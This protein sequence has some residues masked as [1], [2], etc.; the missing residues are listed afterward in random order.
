MASPSV[1]GAGEEKADKEL[2]KL[3]TRLEEESDR[4]AG[5]IRRFQIVS[6]IA[7]AL[8]CVLLS[9][10]DFRPPKWAHVQE[11]LANWE[12]NNQIQ[13]AVRSIRYS[14]IENY[15]F[16]QSVRKPLT[17]SVVKTGLAAD[18]PAER[19]MQ[20][21]SEFL[22]DKYYGVSFLDLD[23]L[24]KYLSLM[25]EQAGANV[26]KDLSNYGYEGGQRVATGT[27][28]RQAF[29]SDYTLGKHKRLAL[30][31]PYEPEKDIRSYVDAARNLIAE[32]KRKYPEADKAWTGVKTG[33]LRNYAV[34]AWTW[35]A[36]TGLSDNAVAEWNSI[37]VGSVGGIDSETI[38]TISGGQGL[39][40]WGSVI[41]W[42]K[43]Q[44][45]A[46]AEAE[47]ET[48]AKATIWSVRVA[49]PLK[50]MVLLFPLIY[51]AARC[52][53]AELRLYLRS[54]VARAK[55]IDAVIDRGLGVYRPL[56]EGLRASLIEPQVI[57]SGWNTIRLFPLFF[58]EFAYEMGAFL[59]AAYVLYRGI[60]LAYYH[61]AT[62]INPI[63]YSLM[64]T[65]ALLLGLSFLRTSRSAI[66]KLSE[67][68]TVTTQ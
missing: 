10:Q 12:A 41:T 40:D 20:Q 11:R 43:R 38:S 13:G 44:V 8:L 52:A 66:K 62:W 48:E 47:K 7:L 4:L 6:L 23:E 17:A 53:L 3:R 24:E 14:E 42:I 9:S 15:Q 32:I 37:V 65:A 5:S 57:P 28:L 54:N 60:H 30:E 55:A 34:A 49:L 64:I 1:T 18:I 63:I 16:T 51:V 59:M 26:L 35:G 45:A 21:V 29:F 25:T 27:S 46:K 50:V 22:G 67:G 56:L 2:E 68:L 33:F 61:P 39:P 19:N 58:T 31:L 36:W